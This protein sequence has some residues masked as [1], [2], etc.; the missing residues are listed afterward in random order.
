MFTDD[1]EY[2]WVKK[3]GVLNIKTF[4]ASYDIDPK[5][6]ITCMWFEPAKAFKLTIP[7]VRVQG[8]IGWLKPVV[9]RILY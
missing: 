3:S 6:V 4:S 8:Y 2:E 7:R 5:D 1:E 9:G